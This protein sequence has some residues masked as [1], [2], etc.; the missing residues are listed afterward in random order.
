MVKTR[1][2]YSIPTYTISVN[3]LDDHRGNFD[4]NKIIG[5]AMSTKKVAPRMTICATLDTDTNIMSFGIARCN[6]N[7]IFCKKTGQLISYKQATT[8]PV[9]V[10]MAPEENI[11]PWRISICRMLEQ[12]YM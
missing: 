4:I 8:N 6:P 5:A 3:V 11:G 10:A 9:Y 7:D 12:K 1:Y 2:Y